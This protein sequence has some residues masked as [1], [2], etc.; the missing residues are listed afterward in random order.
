M[1][2]RGDKNPRRIA[3]RL[4]VLVGLFTGTAVG[5]GYLLSGIP[6]VELMTF[7]VALAGAALGHSLGALCGILAAVVFSLGNP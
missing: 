6:N 5:A 4:T 1:L 7:L 2:T 3:V